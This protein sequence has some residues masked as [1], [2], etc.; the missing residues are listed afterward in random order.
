MVISFFTINVR[1]WGDS[2]QTGIMKHTYDTLAFCLAAKNHPHLL[3]EPEFQ[4]AQAEVDASPEL[5]QQLQ[6]AQD[7]LEKHPVLIS[8]SEMP[9]D[10]RARISSV[11][12][13]QETKQ[14]PA[15]EAVLGPWEVRRNFAWAVC[16]VLLLAGM[17]VLSSTILE[18][19][20]D[21]KYQVTLAEMPPQD[22]FR[23]EIGRL[24]DHGL[25]LQRRS[26]D[27]H[28][29][30]SWLGDQGL[31][32][33]QAPETLMSMPSMGCAKF[34]TPFGNI[35]VVCFNTDGQVIHMFIADASEMGLQ[36]P[37]DPRKFQ[38][39]G[40]PVKEWSDNENLYLLV[41]QEKDSELPEIFL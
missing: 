22:A 24:V 32:D 17:A 15:G 35:A 7:F 5:Q 23:M 13:A 8:T 4:Q 14:A 6:E 3:D 9:S 19:Q 27:P 25:Q 29:L 1:R 20:V 34:E 18:S 26:S 16:L 40:R 30:V 28:Q 39:R 10:V 21:R 37:I 12:E 31:P 38:L 11:L 36:D 33:I 41:P 2:R